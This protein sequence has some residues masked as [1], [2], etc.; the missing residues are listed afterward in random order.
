MLVV[1]L[2]KPVIHKLKILSGRGGRLEYY[3]P[4]KGTTKKGGPSF[5][6]SAEVS[7]WGEHDFWL[8]FGGLK[9][10]TPEIYIQIISK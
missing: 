10:F 2:F 9:E 8:K 5:K 4:M 7:K 3:K 6:I 1:S